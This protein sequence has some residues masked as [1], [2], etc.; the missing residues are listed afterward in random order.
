MW[1]GAAYLELDALFTDV[2]RSTRKLDTDG[3]LRML[4]D[5]DKKV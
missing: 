4:L 2:D 5:W 1:G 3:M